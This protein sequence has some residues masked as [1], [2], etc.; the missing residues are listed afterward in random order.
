VCGNQRCT[1]ARHTNTRSH[2]ARIR[3][4]VAFVSLLL[5]L[6]FLLYCIVS[7][8][9][10]A[11]CC[12]PSARQIS[13]HNHTDNNRQNKTTSNVKSLLLR[14]HTYVVDAT[15]C[16]VLVSCSILVTISLATT[17]NGYDTTATKQPPHFKN[18][19]VRSCRFIAQNISYQI[20]QT[21]IYISYQS[22][23]QF[24]CYE[25]N[26]QIKYNRLVFFVVS[27]NYCQN[28]QTINKNDH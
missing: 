12:Q 8:M 14:Q 26:F 11:F 1:T 27:V 19:R 10:E 2:L 16:V 18:Q 28:S 17:T 7:T 4:L 24:H 3:L 25:T 13:R 6:V 22:C 5:L 21:I 23:E 15:A 20:Y 9:N